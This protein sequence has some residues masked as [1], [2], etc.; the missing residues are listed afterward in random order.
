LTRE[1]QAMLRG[2]RGRRLY[3]IGAW[4]AAAAITYWF[5]YRPDRDRR[6]TKQRSQKPE[7]V[8]SSKLGKNKVVRD[9]LGVPVKPT[10]D[11]SDDI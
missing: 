7:L 5:V 6:I 8:V 2:L 11:R 10:D 1:E 4:A 3:S 9:E